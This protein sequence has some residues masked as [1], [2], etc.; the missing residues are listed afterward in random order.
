[1]LKKSSPTNMKMRF[2]SLTGGSSF[3]CTLVIVV[4]M[5]FVLENEST[6]RASHAETLMV[7]S[8]RAEI[9]RI[10]D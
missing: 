1:M 9:Q 10:A 3:T 5:L 6:Q 7:R 8:G 2:L 4:R